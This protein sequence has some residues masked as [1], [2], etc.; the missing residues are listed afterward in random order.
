MTDMHKHGFVYILASGARGTLYIGV[1]SDLQRRMFEHKQ[2][3]VE[4]FTARYDVTKLVWFLEA[5][6]IRDAIEVEKKFKNRG[7]QW[8]I[9]LIEKSNPNWRDLSDDWI[10]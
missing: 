9:D 7:R 1:T 5:E 4:G 8:K 6:S 2:H 10:A 3:L